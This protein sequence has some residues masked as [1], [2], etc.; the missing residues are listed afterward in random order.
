MKN[1]DY[2]LSVDPGLTGACAAWFGPTLMGIYDMPVDDGEVDGDGFQ[3][4]LD[5]Y[6]PK[7]MVVEKVHSMPQQ[8]VASTFKFGMTYGAVLGIARANRMNVERVRPQT[9]KKYFD[10]LKKDKDSSRLLALELYPSF[11][12]QLELKKHHGRADAILIGR[13]FWKVICQQ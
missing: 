6:I 8:G 10:L 5:K 11:E 3:I 2:W 4:I 9:W 13:Y 7:T 12:H 1:D